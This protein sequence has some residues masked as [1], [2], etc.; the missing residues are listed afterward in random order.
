MK[1]KYVYKSEQPRIKVL[2]GRDSINNKLED[3][4]DFAKEQGAYPKK[5][6]VAP[7]HGYAEFREKHASSSMEIGK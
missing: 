3:F 5:T 1:K 6:V 2:Q 4:I 7:L